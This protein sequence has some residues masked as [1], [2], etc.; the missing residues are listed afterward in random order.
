MGWHL[1]YFSLRK[2][3]SRNCMSFR[4]FP[5]ISSWIF[6]AIFLFSPVFSQYTRAD[7]RYI[8]EE[9]RVL[10]SLRLDFESKTRFYNIMNKINSKINNKKIPDSPSDAN[11][12]VYFA[13]DWSKVADVMSKDNYELLGPEIPE[14]GIGIFYKVLYLKNDPN[15][16]MILI[17]YSVA[18]ANNPS[19]ECFAETT[20]SILS[21]KFNDISR[22]DCG[23][24][25]IER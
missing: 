25:H 4:H 18:E 17:L 7:S 6:C 3:I 5:R 20:A 15:D 19:L 22:E 16:R 12:L 11:V 8:F 2:S 9:Y 23:L 1:S 13:E 21:R 24:S 14:T 10:I